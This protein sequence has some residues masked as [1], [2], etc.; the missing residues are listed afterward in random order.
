MRAKEVFRPNPL[1]TFLGAVLLPVMAL[2]FGGAAVAMLVRTPGTAGVLWFLLF[3]AVAFLPGIGGCLMLRGWF[4]IEVD[5][6]ALSMVGLFNTNRLR[7]PWSDLDGVGLVKWRGARFL[8]VRPTRGWETKPH[9]WAM[10][11][12]PNRRLLLISGVER[13]SR[14][15]EELLGCVREHA[16]TKWRDPLDEPLAD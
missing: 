4:A 9:R 15:T 1:G 11:W 5:E 13:W 12:E 16:G 10:R 8:S 2:F 7:M 14:P 6:A 3:A